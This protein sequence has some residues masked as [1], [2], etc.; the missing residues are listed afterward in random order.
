MKTGGAGAMFNTGAAAR[1]GSPHK[2]GDQR[3]ASSSSLIDGVEGG[4]SKPCEA[5]VQATLVLKDGQ[6]LEGTSFGAKVNRPG[7]VVFNTGMVGYPE[8]LTDP[9]YRGQILVL[10][11]PLVGNYGVPSMDTKDKWDLPLYFESDDVQIAGLVVSNY[12]A[13]PSHWASQQSL[14]NWLAKAGVPAIFGVDTRALTKG[15]RERGSILGRLEVEGAPPSPPQ[16]VGFVDPNLRNLVAEVSTK[17]IRTY[18]Q[19]GDKPTIVAIDCGMKHNIV[20]YFVET[21]DVTLI[22]VPFD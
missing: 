11:F 12:S 18:N 5:P 14:G 22:V 19:G 15:L 9:S 17:T 16:E 7:E 3:Y 4:P 2:F 13:D 20:R 21:H 8:A 1:G 6:R 10:T